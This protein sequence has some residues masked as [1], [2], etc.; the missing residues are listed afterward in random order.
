[1]STIPSRWLFIEFIAFI[2]CIGLLD[3]MDWE[4]KKVDPKKTIQ[5]GSFRVDPQGNQK[6]YEVGF[7]ISSPTNKTLEKMYCTLIM[8]LLQL[9]SDQSS[10]STFILSHYMVCFHGDR[11][12]F[13]ETF[14]AHDTLC[15][16]TI[17]VDC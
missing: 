9:V 13:I 1:M 3:E 17:D 7:S 5:V 8:L 2:A 4:I 10:L 6:L 16:C 15:I 12:D 11:S 14:A